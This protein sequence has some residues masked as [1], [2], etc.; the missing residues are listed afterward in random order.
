VLTI[1]DGKTCPICK[2]IYKNIIFHIKRKHPE[3]MDKIY[4]DINSFYD[5]NLYV[6]EIYVKLIKDNP[7]YENIISEY[8]ISKIYKRRGK[9]NRE[10]SNRIFSIRRKGENNTAK[11]KEVK[12]KIKKTVTNLWKEGKYKDRIN[13]MLGRSK[14][15]SLRYKPEKHTPLYLAE[16]DCVKFLSNFQDVKTCSRCGRKDIKMNIHHIDEDH[17]NFLISNLE[18][19]CV[20]CHMSFHYGH[21]KRE[22]LTIVKSFNLDIAH[23]LPTSHYIGRCNAF[24]G[25]RLKCEVGVKKR[26]DKNTGMVLDFKILKEI[27][28]GFI[29]D[30]L[31]HSLLNDFLENPTSENLCVWMW[32][33]LMFDAL[34]KGIEYIR[35][36]E[37]DSS[38]TTLDKGGMLSMF[39]TN[40]EDYLLKFSEDKNENI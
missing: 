9:F 35:I 23:F 29:I 27:I 21:S 11:K 10:R 15:L 5:S 4:S 17:S 32:E 30:S 31:D 19:L 40:I 2:K 34:L 25:H 3:Y 13:G 24:H 28:N 33:K 38:F 12:E 36:W 8:M 26:V 16:H 1:T 18:P 7:V 22:Y 20:P 14:E 39:K 37:T 6:K